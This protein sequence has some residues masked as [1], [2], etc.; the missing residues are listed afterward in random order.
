MGDNPIK[1]F[2]EPRVILSRRLLH[3]DFDLLPLREEVCQAEAFGELLALHGAWQVLLVG[4]DQNW[5]TL[6]ILICEQGIELFFCFLHAVNT[7]RVYDE[8]D[9]FYTLIVVLPYV[10]ELVLP[11][12]VVNLNVN[13]L[14]LDLLRCKSDRRGRLHPIQ[15]ILHP[16]QNC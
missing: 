13:V 7:A 2:P 5:H 4:E 1:P 12:Q 10:P 3:L 8:D 14:D 9:A 15:V 6:S 11:L 16:L